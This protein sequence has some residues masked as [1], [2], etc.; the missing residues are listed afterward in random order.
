MEDEGDES[1]EYIDKAECSASDSET[2]PVLS[3]D[4]DEGEQERHVEA[5]V[6]ESDDTIKQLLFHIQQI[7]FSPGSVAICA[8]FLFLHVQYS[9]QLHSAL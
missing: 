8:I 2:E 9:V 1:P 3:G 7:L 4:Q 5:A 6:C